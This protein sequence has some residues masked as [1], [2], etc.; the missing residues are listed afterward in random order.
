MRK[1]KHEINEPKLSKRQM[2]FCLFYLRD[3]DSKKAV[4]KSGLAD[5]E[6]AATEAVKLLSTE[7]VKKEIKYLKSETKPIIDINSL[8]EFYA[9]A[10]LADYSD[11]ITYYKNENDEW[12]S[13]IDVSK[14]DG[15]MIEE[16]VAVKGGVKIK[17]LDRYKALEKLGK[18]LGEEDI[19]EE[20]NNNNITVVT[21][22]LRPEKTENI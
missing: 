8:I 14:I 17:F 1:T 16:I 10:A 4:I 7:S 3:F 15:Q 5:A 11:C 20:T 21:A 9:R 22:A 12:V 18:Y 13:D 19:E 2:L 6:N